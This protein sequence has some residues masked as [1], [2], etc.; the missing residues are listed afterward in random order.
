VLLLVRGPHSS[1]R[2]DGLKITQR[3]P[4]WVG[5]ARRLDRLVFGRLQDDFISRLECALG[6]CESVL[7]VGCGANS[8][9]DRLPKRV[10]YSVGV[11]LY[12]PWIEESRAKGIHD[13]YLVADIRHLDSYFAPK[14]MDC[15]LAADVLEHLDKADGFRLI[16][17]MDR[18]A[19]KSVVIFTPN[20]YLE[21]HPT[22]GNPL[23]IHRSG[24]AASEMQALGY[25]VTGINGWRPL[26]GEYARAK[27]RPRTLWSR[28][29]LVSQLLTNSRPTHAFALLCVKRVDRG[30]SSGA[31]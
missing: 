29:S 9:I 26:R 17:L 22:G 28:I 18:I 23:Q 30:L 2:L 6:D 16:S 10:P 14:S 19:R 5:S 31:T 20:G 1:R 3:M 11:D 25:E 24:W 21:Q 27:W 7:D 13:R 4:N 15:V 8:P 12:E